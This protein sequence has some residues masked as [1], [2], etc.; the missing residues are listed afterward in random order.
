[1]FPVAIDHRL[2]TIQ[3]C[4]RSFAYGHKVVSLHRGL[5][6]LP[7]STRPMAED[8][9]DLLG[10]AKKLR[11]RIRDRVILLA[12]ANHQGIERFYDQA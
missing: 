2:W 1:M 3:S 5:S 12:T 8:Q 7:L 4:E 10:N 11:D 6:M 9:D